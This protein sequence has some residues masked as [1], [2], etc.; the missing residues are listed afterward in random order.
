MERIRDNIAERSSLMSDSKE[1]RHVLISQYE[2]FFR[3]TLK[4][5]LLRPVLRLKGMP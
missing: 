3:L 1:Q 2:T 5:R 4:R